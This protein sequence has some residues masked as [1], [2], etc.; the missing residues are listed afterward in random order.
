MKTPNIFKQVIILLAV[1]CLITRLG[2]IFGAKQIPVMW[3]ARLYSSA[4]LGLIHYLDN[5]EQFGHPENLTRADSAH[6]Q[7]EFTELMRDNIQGEQIEWLYYKVPTVQQAQ[8]YIF[9]SGPVYPALLAFLFSIV[10]S[11]EFTI[12]RIINAVVDSICVIF[13]MLIAFRLFGKTASIISGILYI[14]YLPFI[15]VTGMV[16]MEP[17]TILMIL[18]CVFVILLFYEDKKKLWLYIIGVLLG[19]LVVTKPTATLLFVPFLA[20]FLYDMRRDFKSALKSIVLAGIPFIIIVLP[21]IIISSNYYDTLAIRDPGYSEANLRSSSSVKFEG[22]DLDIVSEDFWTRPI[23]SDIFQ[24][25]VG[26]F[27]LFIKKFIRLWGQPYND[28]AQ[29]FIITPRLSQ[30]LHYIIIIFGFFG[31]FI[32]LVKREKG[33]SYLF[34]IPAYYTLIHLIFHS[35][36]RYNLNAMPFMIIAGSGAMIYACRYIAEKLKKGDEKDFRTRVIFFIVGIPFVIFFPT[37][38]AMNMFGVTSGVIAALILRIF[39]LA[40][41]AF[42]L[43]RAITQKSDAVTT[44]KI[45]TIPSIVFFLLLFATGSYPE[46][47]AE[48]KCPLK[49]RK[50]AAG[51]LIYFPPDF[52]LKPGEQ[53]LIGID[54]TTDRNRERPFNVY[55]NGKLHNFT[56]AESPIKDFHYGKFTYRVF[57]NLRDIEMEEM[58][59]WRRIPL[60]SQMF[61]QLLDEVGYIDIAITNG[62]Y[63]LEK[64]HMKIYGQYR[65]AEKDEIYMPTLHYSS[66]ERFVQ[67]GDPRV[68]LNYPLSSDSVISYYINDLDE[69]S[70]NTDDLSPA[71]GV[72]T[73]RL[74]IIIETKMQDNSRLYF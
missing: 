59:A 54:M 7:I 51:T 65:V 66:I 23:Y 43:A 38:Y 61:N 55:I 74:R 9:L 70:F 14:L 31:V 57:E 3:D 36:A 28:Y 39:I 49:N 16:S 40:I 71:P 72:Q 10:P 8:D 22:Y 13:L 64:N 67:K 73:G 19:L 4:A 52:R 12:V 1:I 25:P 27:N 68:W 46:N 69:G 62:D 45:V 30:G 50:Q 26:Y 33:Y 24:Q 58:R 34:L 17:I 21:W 47:W 18:A 53:A 44:F 37:N 56:L 29:S 20:G 35:L 2:F 41:M 6:Y 63:P 32:F 48:W 15:I 60:N 42:Y 11:A 5:S